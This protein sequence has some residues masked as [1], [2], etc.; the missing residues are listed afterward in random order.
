MPTPAAFTITDRFLKTARSSLGNKRELVR[1]ET[2]TGLGVRVSRSNI[3]FICQL[4]RKGRTPYR[5]TL[6]AYGVLTIAQA[7]DAVR[8]LAGKIAV[9]IDPDDERRAEARERK[10]E[11]E[12]A[13][14]A[15]FT[16][17]ALVEHW[18]RDHLSTQRP[19]Y[20][21]A[22]HRR[23]IQHF[24]RLLDIPAHLIDRKEVRRAVEVAR[25]EAG[26]A[27][28]RNGLVSLK[29]AFSW[30]LSHDLIDANPLT[31]FKAPPATASRE[32]VLSL[33][34]ARRV[35]SAALGLPYP[36]GPVVRLLL[37]T[38]C[39]RSEIAGLRWEEVKRD[40]DDPRIELPS[41]RTKTGAGHRVPLSKAALQ[42]IDECYNSH[43][44]VGS[45][46]V[47][48]S[49]GAVAFRNWARI[50]ERLDE[51]LEDG[52]EG[53]RY[54]DFRRTIVSILAAKGF[55]PIVLD[56]LLG[57]QPRTLS[58]IAGVYQKHE[59]ADE[60]REALECWAEA[61][62]G[63]GAEVVAIRERLG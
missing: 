11:A 31:G 61:L 9:G 28:A 30:A 21:K 39:R 5:A 24:G 25:E 43:R 22:A 56:K 1:F 33:G 40:A 36:G 15:R 42:M 14:Q 49:D 47:F 4:P 20:A 23:V 45:P 60:R 29:S 13:E 35:W 8:V 34:E 26:A 51:A 38:G 63:P 37:L 48:T 27:G 10:A 17:R 57:H 44:I 62:T 16:L 2:T 53:W 54:H 46:Y 58:A 41:A 59:H 3:G 6:G 18:R 19:D 7:R 55:N 50:K 32:R 12:A 52:M